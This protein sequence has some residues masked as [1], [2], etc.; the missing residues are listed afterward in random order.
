MKGFVRI[1]FD[2]KILLDTSRKFW[3]TKQQYSLYRRYQKL[4]TQTS[5]KRSS[6]GGF[7]CREQTP[8]NWLLNYLIKRIITI[9]W[10]VLEIRNVLQL[11]IWVF[12]NSHKYCCLDG[13]FYLGWIEN[14]FMFIIPWQ[15]VQLQ[16]WPSGWS[17]VSLNWAAFKQRFNILT[18]SSGK[19]H[20][21]AL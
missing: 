21:E 3:L 13:G 10:Q 17:Q 2:N 9:M 18:F 12:V 11:G 19:F 6:F 14:I 15:G 8:E 16:L 4:A 20:L 5:N 7:S 1:A